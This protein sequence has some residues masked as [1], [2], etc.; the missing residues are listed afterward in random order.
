VGSPGTFRATQLGEGLCPLYGQDNVFCVGTG[1]APSSVECF[2]GIK[3]FMIS[4]YWIVFVVLTCMLLLVL[5]WLHLEHRLYPNKVQYPYDKAICST[6]PAYILILFAQQIIAFFYGTNY[7]FRDISVVEPTILT[8][9]GTTAGSFLTV[10]GVV[11]GLLIAQIVGI[12]HE[13]FVTIRNAL[14]EELASC[15][16]VSVLIKSIAVKGTHCWGDNI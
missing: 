14:S 2:P 6:L 1:C 4:R 8:Y 3:E 12:V 16:Q 11:Y 13:K 5:V 10:V 7:S 9:L 15:Q